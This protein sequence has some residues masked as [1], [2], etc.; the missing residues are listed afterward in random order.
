MDVIAR[1]DF[2][3]A[4]YDSAV[5]R[6]HHEGTPRKLSELDVL[7]AIYNFWDRFI[8]DFREILKQILEMFFPYL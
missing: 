4:Y 3:L 1:L 6:L 7:L 5:Y 8:R 2:E